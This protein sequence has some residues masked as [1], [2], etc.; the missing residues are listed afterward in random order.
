MTNHRITKRIRLSTV[1]NS[2]QEIEN[3]RKT[4]SKTYYLKNEDNFLDFNQFFKF[5]SPLLINKLKELHNTYSYKFNL[6]VDCVYENILTNE[7]R[8]VAF[9]TKNEII[10]TTSD[11]KPILNQ[12]FD[13]LLKEESNFL[14]KGL[15]W[16]LKSIHGL[17]LRTNKVNLI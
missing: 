9:K 1:G 6:Y 14:I 13:K 4:R 17:Q 11:L 7:N 3:F 15:G 8:D 12:M 10:H 16:S 5:A 2:L